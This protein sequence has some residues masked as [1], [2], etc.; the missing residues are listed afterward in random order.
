MKEKKDAKSPLPLFLKMTWIV[1]LT[2]CLGFAI[3]YGVWGEAWMETCAITFGITAYHIFI[4]FA[5]PVIL[6]AVCKRNYNYNSR[7]FQ[8]KKWEPKVYGALKVKKWKEHIP[9]YDPS[10]FSLKKHSVEEIVVNMCHAEAVH[11]LI[12]VLGFT[13]LLFGIPFGC[14]PVFFITALAAGCVDSVFV[15]LQR[16]NRPRM[17][18]IL[19]RKQKEVSG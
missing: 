16:Y 15:I 14:F 4:R 7:W 19:L 18:K 10:E 8:Q 1:S 12:V 17:L 5:S 6:Y 13:T 11:E 2:F 3:L 9:A